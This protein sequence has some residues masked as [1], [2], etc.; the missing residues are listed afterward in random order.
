MTTRILRLE[1]IWQD[2]EGEFV[3]QHLNYLDDDTQS[4]PDII[5]WGTTIVSGLAA[6]TNM[7]LSSWSVRGTRTFNTHTPP[8]QAGKFPNS[9][10]KLSLQAYSVTGNPIKLSIGA[11]VDSDIGPDLETWVPASYA[12]LKTLFSTP[13]TTTGAVITDTAGNAF[14]EFGSGYRLRTK[15]KKERPGQAPARG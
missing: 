15:S 7:V 12:A 14:K 4:T 3:N 10:D 2:F 6:H 8:T 1:I 9:E 11:P 5:T 13:D